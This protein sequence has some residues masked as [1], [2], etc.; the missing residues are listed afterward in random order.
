MKKTTPNPEYQSHV[1][2]GDLTND[3]LREHKD[4]LDWTA[5]CRWQKLEQSFIEQMDQYVNWIA[6][7]K[8]QLH[9]SEDF[10][11][12]N[13]NKLNKPLLAKHTTFSQ[14]FLREF[15]NCINWDEVVINQELTID[16]IREFRD[17][18]PFDYIFEHQHQFKYSFCD[19]YDEVNKQF[20]QYKE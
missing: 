6:I 17:Q 19:R 15:R 18:L 11:R 12:R 9:L 4:Q 8:W 2:F 10:I 13:W 16:F 14:S 3:W 5:V 7:S 1:E 20:Q